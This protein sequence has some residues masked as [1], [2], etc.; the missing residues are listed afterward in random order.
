MA[1]AG[2]QVRTV[3]S[4]R[5][6]FR[7]GRATPSGHGGDT[8]IRDQLRTVYHSG[9]ENEY[10]FVV[11]ATRTAAGFDRLASTLVLAR[12]LHDVTGVPVAS[13]TGAAVAL[14]VRGAPLPGVL[15]QLRQRLRDDVSPPPR[16][17]M[18]SLP[19][20]LGLAFELLDELTL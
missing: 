16:L 6:W 9:R 18:E 2:R 12:V 19:G 17:W 15:A 5:R 20:T 11:V 1:D 13:R 4:T 10:S 8:A 7:C 3:M 14:L